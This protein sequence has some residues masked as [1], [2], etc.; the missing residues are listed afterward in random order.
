MGWYSLTRLGK[1]VKRGCAEKVSCAHG[2]CYHRV[3]EVF[4]TNSTCCFT[5]ICHRMIEFQFPGLAKIS[6][7]KRGAQKRW[8]ALMAVVTMMFLRS[9]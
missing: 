3:P 7:G 6:M 9:F 1:G 5:P 4:L 2:G 8:A